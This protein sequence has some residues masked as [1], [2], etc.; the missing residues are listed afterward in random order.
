MN[1]MM[2]DFSSKEFGQ[3]TLYGYSGQPAV[4]I[5]HDKQVTVIS[6]KDSEE[7]SKLYEKLLE[8]ID[9]PDS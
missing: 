9:Q 6:E 4:K 5:I 2:G 8:I 1:K 7:T 3:Y